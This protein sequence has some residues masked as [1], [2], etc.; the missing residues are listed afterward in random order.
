MPDNP[1]PQELARKFCWHSDQ[2]HAL[3][4]PMGPGCPI[5]E[6]IA[7]VI[8]E[9]DQQHKAEL[10]RAHK[11]AAA[12]Q[13]LFP[14]TA[15]C[16]KEA[17]EILQTNYIGPRNRAKAELASV[18]A[19]QAT[20]EGAIRIQASQ[21]NNLMAERDQ[22]R[23]ERDA[24]MGKDDAVHAGAQAAITALRQCQNVVAERDQLREAHLAERDRFAAHTR[25]VATFLSEMYAIMVDPLADGEM[26]V[27]ETMKSLKDAALRDRELENKL[28]RLRLRCVECEGLVVYKRVDEEIK[29]FHTCTP[30]AVRQSFERLQEKNKL[31]VNAIVAATHYPAEMTDR[32][33]LVMQQINTA[34]AANK[35]DQPK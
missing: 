1:T 9:R 27:S 34:L 15:M 18:R 16:M 35:E 10:E 30:K 22:L 19:E 23:Q 26:K 32:H 17:D 13:H 25:A 8:S 28:E 20:N 12:F 24:L 5:C 33:S 31:L 11:I 3:M 14:A 7:A 4:S 21:V 2:F 29:I 6:A